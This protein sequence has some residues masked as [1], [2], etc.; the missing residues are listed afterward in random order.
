T[1][2]HGKERECSEV[3]T[4]G[5]WRLGMPVRRIPA[6]RLPLPRRKAIHS[7][8]NTRGANSHER[9]PENLCI[10]NALEYLLPARGEVIDEKAL[11]DA[12]LH[13]WYNQTLCK[14][15]ESVVRL[16]V[17]QGE[18]H[19]HKHDDDEF[20]YYVLEGRLLIDLES[21]TV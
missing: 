19:W 4:S 7:P 5:S 10:R 11:A 20:F 14:V 13:K 15:N 1:A 21:G 3:A 2:S 8:I 16:G 6:A 17:V 12:C 9:N 18:Y